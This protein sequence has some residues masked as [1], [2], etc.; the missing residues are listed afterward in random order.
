MLP[1]ARSLGAFSLNS[2]RTQVEKGCWGDVSREAIR[3]SQPPSCKGKKK[4]QG[5]V[6]L[7]VVMRKQIG[8][9]KTCT[10]FFD[11]LLLGK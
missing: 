2:L 4:R 3:V 10:F 1:T 5:L 8:K 7:N 9:S 6:L 11:R